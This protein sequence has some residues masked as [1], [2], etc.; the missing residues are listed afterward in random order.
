MPYYLDAP[1]L[2]LATA[3]YTNAA[4]SICAADGV[5]SDG[6]ITRVQTSC[7]LG[8]AKFCPSCGEDCGVNLGESKNQP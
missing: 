2:S 8:P 4:L 1:S 5:Y 6:T 7:V 3:V